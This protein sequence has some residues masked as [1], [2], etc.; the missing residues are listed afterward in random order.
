LRGQQSRPLPFQLRCSPDDVT[1]GR[2]R[3]RGRSQ[4]QRQKGPVSLF[5]LA[6]VLMLFAMTS[7]G[8]FLATLAGSMP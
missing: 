2:Q 5:I 8:I 3:P 4:L 6:S 7:M 1:K